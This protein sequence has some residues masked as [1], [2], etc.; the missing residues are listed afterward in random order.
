[1][2]GGG[3]VKSVQAEGLFISDIRSLNGSGERH[4]CTERVSQIDARKR[5][6]RG[7][8]ISKVFISIPR[9]SVF[10]VFGFR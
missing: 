10:R 3:G 6:R 9:Y 8:G 1:M 5:K 4:G 7:G 2:G